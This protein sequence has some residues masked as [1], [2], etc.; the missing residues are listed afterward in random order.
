M[1]VFLNGMGKGKEMQRF[2]FAIVLCLSA[3][4]QL[5][6]Q[7]NNIGGKVVDE[8]GE[9]LAFANVALLNRQD[10]TFVKGVV[11]GADGSFVID[12]PCNG[13]IVKITS[14]GYKTA[15]CDCR[16]EDVGIVRLAED[17]KMLGEVV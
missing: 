11:S 10:S 12:S 9:P 13:G 7:N 17:S 3:M 14:I 8:K 4:S 1:G 2:V 6:A 15:F 5:M 16:G